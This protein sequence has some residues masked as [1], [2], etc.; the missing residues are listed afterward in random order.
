MAG[1]HQDRDRGITF[2]YTLIGW[3][4]RRRRAAS[5]TIENHVGVTRST[6]SAQGRPGPALCIDGRR[7]RRV[8]HIR[9]IWDPIN[10]REP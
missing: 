6:R 9:H 5:S 1:S 3:K 7:A 8:I 4:T 10:R 2:A